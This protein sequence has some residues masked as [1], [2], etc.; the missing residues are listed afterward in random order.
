M[1]VTMNSVLAATVMLLGFS[2]AAPPHTPAPGKP[3]FPTVVPGFP[4]PT[5]TRPS[6][7]KCPP[8]IVPPQ[9]DIGLP[10]SCFTT[11]DDFEH[12]T[13]GVDGPLCF[14]WTTT[15]PAVTCPQIHCASPP[16][17][18]ACPLYLRVS[19]TTVPCATDC[20]P[21]TPTATYSCG[22]CPTCNPCRVPTILSVF[23]TGCPGTPTVTS[24]TTITPP[25]W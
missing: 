15:A 10:A 8:P 5:K 20:C 2:H 3:P 12:S 9:P 18:L 22:P 14:T 1:F 4:G 13:A 19:S 11:W 16:P 7:T 17:D 23:T 6:F 25:F 24:V 21:F